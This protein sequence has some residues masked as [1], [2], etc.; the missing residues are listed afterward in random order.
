MSNED[1][2]IENRIDLFIDEVAAICK[3][4]GV[5]ISSGADAADDTNLSSWIELCKIK[6]RQIETVFTCEEI[7]PNGV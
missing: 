3:K 1:K 5:I 2:F 7:G 6:N 4:Y